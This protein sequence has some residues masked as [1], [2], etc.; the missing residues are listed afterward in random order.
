MS[1]LLDCCVCQSWWMWDFD[2]HVP[3]RSSA[4]RQTIWNIEQGLPVFTCS[5]VNSGFQLICSRVQTMG[6]GRWRPM[7]SFW[8]ISL[9][10]NS[11]GR[12]GLHLQRSRVKGSSAFAHM[13]F[14]AAIEYSW[15][16]SLCCLGVLDLKVIFLASRP[17]KWEIAVTLPFFRWSLHCLIFQTTF[18]VLRLA[19]CRL[20]QMHATCVAFAM[21]SVLPRRSHL[22]RTSTTCVQPVCCYVRPCSDRG[23]HLSDST[24]ALIPFLPWHVS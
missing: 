18:V 10:T 22:F 9:K 24:C 17:Q 1:E 7:M 21:F 3:H 2:W 5:R 13:A 11:V 6:G 4:Q 20:L 14:A 15:C 19:E 12:P 8:W 16:P 23:H